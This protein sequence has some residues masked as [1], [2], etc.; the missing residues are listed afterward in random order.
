MRL[1][2]V[3]PGTPIKIEIIQGKKK[4]EFD[5]QAVAVMDNNLLINCI[6]YQNAVLNLNVKNVQINL[7]AFM[8]LYPIEKPH[9]LCRN[10]GSGICS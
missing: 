7:I 3:K 1:N 4:L 9:L 8:L 10:S 2:E 6:R 5:S